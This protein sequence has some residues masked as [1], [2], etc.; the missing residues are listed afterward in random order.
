MPRTR[1]LLLALAL[2]L[3]L[4]PLLATP[5]LVGAQSSPYKPTVIPVDVTFEAPFLTSFCGFSVMVHVT[6]TLTIAT[7]PGGVGFEQLRFQYEF[8]GPG[9]SRTIK[10]IENY[11]YTT[12]ASPDGTLVETLTITGRLRY[13]NIVPGLGSI[14]G[15]SGREVLLITYEYDEE[16]GEYVEVEVQVLFDAGLNDEPTDADFEIICA[17]LD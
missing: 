12:V 11:K 6:G 1:W 16:L 5:R 15:N 3:G 9:G 10:V 2:L 8:T 4:T 13:H 17:I 14:S 7:R